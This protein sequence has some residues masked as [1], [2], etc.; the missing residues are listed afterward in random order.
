MSWAFKSVFMA[1]SI[2]GVQFTPIST[3]GSEYQEIDLGA[4]NDKTRPPKKPKLRNHVTSAEG[5]NDIFIH[6]DLQFFWPKVYRRSIAF[7]VSQLYLSIALTLISTLVFSFT[8]VVFRKVSERVTSLWMTAFKTVIAFFAFFI[9]SLCVP[10]PDLNHLDSNKVIALGALA[11]SGFVGLG[12]CDTFV[13]KAFTMIGTTRAFVV[14][15]FQPVFI[16]I[17]ALLFLQQSLSLNQ[18]IGMALLVSC[19]IILSIEELKGGSWGLKGT[20]CA[21]AAAFFD[22][23]GVLLTRYAFNHWPEIHLFHANFIRVLGGLL[24][25]VLIARFEKINL[26]ANFKIMPRDLKALAIAAG[27]CGTFVSLYF[28]LKAISIGHL[29]TVGAVGGLGPLFVLVFESLVYRQWPSK[30]TIAS[31]I[32]SIIGMLFIVNP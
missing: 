4:I 17:G 3:G 25:F 20:L 28:W 16:A 8:A 5:L 1:H 29:A 19:V 2:A 14:F 27:F 21:L 22:G 15:R 13:L 23:V 24:T 18:G 30:Y 7:A 11:L 26:V 6:F 10:I 32:I 12:V 9:A 31:V